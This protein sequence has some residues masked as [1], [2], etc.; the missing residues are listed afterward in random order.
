M[1]T[2]K[3]PDTQKTH[4]LVP[5]TSLTL[6][7]VPFVNILYSLPKHVYTTDFSADRQMVLKKSMKFW[8]LSE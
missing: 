4:N 3:A 7:S 1:A 6:I 5:E 2:R 8:G